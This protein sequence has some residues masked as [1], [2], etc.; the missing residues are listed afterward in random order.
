[1]P[2]NLILLIAALIVAWI[3]FRALLNVL[4][5]AITTV[6][7]I[8]VIIVILMFFGFSPEDLIQEVNN[9][10]KTLEELFNTQ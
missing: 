5:T 2:T 7:A 3:I 1:M 9:L 4:K 8:V 10:P 6:I